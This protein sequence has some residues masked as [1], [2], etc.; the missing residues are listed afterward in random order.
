MQFGSNSMLFECAEH[1]CI[2]ASWSSSTSITVQ[3]KGLNSTSLLRP[4]VQECCARLEQFHDACLCLSVA[5]CS[6]QSRL[7]VCNDSIFGYSAVRSKAS[8]AAARANGVVLFKSIQAA[9]VGA[10]GSWLA[11]VPH[12]AANTT[13][14][15]GRLSTVF[16]T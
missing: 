10:N 4:I 14:C 5:V 13:S 12:S 15:L 6:S 7:R 11:V 16:L 9:A 2:Y 8:L 3:M 1:Y